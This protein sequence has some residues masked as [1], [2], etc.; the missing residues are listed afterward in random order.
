MIFFATIIVFSRASD[1]IGGGDC[2]DDPVII[3][4]LHSLA[5][6]ELLLFCNET[7]LNRTEETGNVP[8]AYI[9]RYFSE[10]S[11]F[12]E[13]NVWCICIEEKRRLWV[14]VLRYSHSI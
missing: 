12:D 8:H 5:P 4:D 2:F 11:E 9:K 10:N 1:N 13:C 14:F 7:C 6:P 3:K